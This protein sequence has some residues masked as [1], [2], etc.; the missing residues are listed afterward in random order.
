MPDF[1]DRATLLA[2]LTDTHERTVTPDLFGK[3]PILIRE[4]TG[5]Q[6]QMAIQAAQTDDPDN[7]DDAL[8][9]AMLIQMAVVDPDSGT[10]GPDG[11]IDPRTRTPL[12][13]VA[14]VESI[15]N[16]RD[17]ATRAL[18]NDIAALAGLLP[19]ALFRGD[20][21]PDRP[22]RDT[23]E[24]DPDRGIAAHETEDTRSGDHDQ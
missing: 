9:R 18:S 1:L 12:L 13:T 11:R 10:P 6:R 21:A 2:C 23:D 16:G 20:P 4:I 7:P 17:L 5:R 24:G 19:A 14:D 15:A 3:R 8:Y 22:Q